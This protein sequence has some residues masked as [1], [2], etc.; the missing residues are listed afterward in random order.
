MQYIVI[1]PPPPPSVARSRILCSFEIYRRMC[2]QYVVSIC[3]VITTYHTAR[4]V[5]LNNL[6]WE[7]GLHITKREAF[8]SILPTSTVNKRL[9]VYNFVVVS[10]TCLTMTLINTWIF[11][12]SSIWTTQNRCR[13]FF[14]EMQ[15]SVVQKVLLKLWR[16]LREDID[17]FVYVKYTRGNCLFFTYMHTCPEL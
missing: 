12:N 17:R 11:E 7:V 6:P 4:T 14:V 16:L 1:L 15:K 8:S 2:Y 5:W 9:A 3:S 13:C 10:F